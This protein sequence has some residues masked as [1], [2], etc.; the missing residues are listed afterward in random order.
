MLLSD[1]SGQITTLH[2]LEHDKNASLKVKHFFA[3]DQLRTSKKLEHAAFV[4]N[5]LPLF[6]ILRFSMLQSKSLSI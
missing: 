2:I 3:V 1:Y 6:I 5:T 4:N